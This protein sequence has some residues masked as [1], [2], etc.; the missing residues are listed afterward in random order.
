MESYSYSNDDGLEI[1]HGDGS[2]AAA[3]IFPTFSGETSW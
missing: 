3:D 1:G 2:E